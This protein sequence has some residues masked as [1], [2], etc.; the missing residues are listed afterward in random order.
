MADAAEMVRTAE[1]RS[2]LATH[3]DKLA[4]DDRALPEKKAALPPR[5][6]KRSTVSRIPFDQYSS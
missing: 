6:M 5:A 4:E 1:Q 3:F 2:N